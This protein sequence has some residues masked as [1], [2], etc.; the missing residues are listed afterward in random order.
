MRTVAVVAALLFATAAFAADDPFHPADK[1]ELALK[2]VPFSP[3]ASAVVLDWKI[4]QDDVKRYVTE[5]VR[6]KVLN[7]NGRKYATV[8]IPYDDLR[9]GGLEAFHDG[10]A[11]S[12][13]AAGDHGGAACE[14][15]PVH[16]FFQSVL[17]RL[18]VMSM[19]RRAAARAAP[20]SPFATASRIA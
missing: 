10:G 15:E 14:V 17:Q 20:G 8:E 6:I 9:A 3:D 19:W 5:Y 16:D 13:H 11:D 18:R 4:D 2:S 12:L 1:D 7:E